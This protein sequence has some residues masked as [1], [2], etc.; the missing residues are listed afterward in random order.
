MKSLVSVVIPAYNEVKRI[1]QTVSEAQTFFTQRQQPYEIIVSA[2]GD[3]GTREAVSEMAKT[4]PMLRVIGSAGRGGKGRGVRQGVALAKGDIIGYSDADNKT[5]IDEY[6]KLEPFFDQGYDV[7]IGSRALSESTIERRQPLYRQLGS[8]GFSVFMHAVVGLPGIVDSQCGFKFFRRAAAVDLFAR[9][10][11]D[12][13]MFDVEI[14]HLALKAGYRIA[15]V[16]IRWRDDGDSR[17]VLVGGN[18]RNVV[19]VFRIRF[20]AYPDKAGR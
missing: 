4:D 14:L 1:A 9:Q 5:P 17:L 2:D 13:Y 10:R 8:R 11:I 16:P 6:A 19:D 3:D 15:Q 12:G 7:V 20:G 18:L